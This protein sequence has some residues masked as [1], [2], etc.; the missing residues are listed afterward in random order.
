VDRFEAILRE[1]LE[2]DL[3]R[4]AQD[5]FTLNLRLDVDLLASLRAFGLGTH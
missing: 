4:F 2:L 5:L 1:L 3:S